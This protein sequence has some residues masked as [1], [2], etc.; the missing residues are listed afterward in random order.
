MHEQSNKTSKAPLSEEDLVVIGMCAGARLAADYVNTNV[1]KTHY[2]DVRWTRIP[3]GVLIPGME[4]EARILSPD[5][6]EAYMMREDFDV[7][8]DRAMRVLP[9]G[10]TLYIRK[11]EV[12]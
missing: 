5:Q 11:L 3:A 7:S 4:I 8:S 1:G 6:D 12:S 10:S 9:F 2:S